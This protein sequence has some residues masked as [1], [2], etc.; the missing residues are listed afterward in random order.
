MSDIEDWQKALR[1][2]QKIADEISN[3]VTQ[4]TIEA[5]SM[6]KAKQL[7]EQVKRGTIHLREMKGNFSALP[8]L[9]NDYRN[10]YEVGVD[11]MIGQLSSSQEEL[12]RHVEDFS[13]TRHAGLLR[14][15][16]IGGFFIAAYTVA[17]DYLKKIPTPSPIQEFQ[18]AIVCGAAWGSIYLVPFVIKSFKKGQALICG[19]SKKESD[20]EM[21]SANSAKSQCKEGSGLINNGEIKPALSSQKQVRPI[22]RRAFITM[23]FVA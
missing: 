10:P 13:I 20:T 7:R 4:F 19:Q 1:E 17:A 22:S 12:D 11:K 16:A 21:A 18:I 8:P 6:K 15:I 23:R 2:Q 3:R 5:S 14:E 9:E